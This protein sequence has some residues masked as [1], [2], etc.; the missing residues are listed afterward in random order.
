[1]TAAPIHS[2][3]SAAYRDAETHPP[4]QQIVLLHES[5]IRDLRAAQLAIRER[6][7]EARFRRVMQAH[8]IVGALQSCLDFER[9]GEIAPLLDRLYGHV[10]SRLTLIN[11]RNDAAICGELVTLLGKLRE[12]WATVASGAAAPTGPSIPAEAGLGL[13]SA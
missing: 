10:L 1:M 5:A 6:R 3:A 9:G 2:R 12:G 7:I 11:L 13:L 4:A 8:A